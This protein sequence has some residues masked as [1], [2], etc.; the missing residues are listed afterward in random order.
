MRTSNEGKEE[1]ANP[2]K[3]FK[4][5]LQRLKWFITSRIRKAHKAFPP[6]PTLW[7]EHKWDTTCCKQDQPFVFIYYYI[8]IIFFIHGGLIFEK[9]IQSKKSM[10]K[11]LAYEEQ[12]QRLLDY[13]VKLFLPGFRKW[14]ISPFLGHYDRP[15]IA[16]WLDRNA[17]AIKEKD[18]L[19]L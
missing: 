5:W 17:V 14:S 13:T 18:K 1:Q 2:W 16:S 11:F 9:P 6:Q 19:P 10:S 12:L 15:E 3:Y 7:K 8:Y 4:T